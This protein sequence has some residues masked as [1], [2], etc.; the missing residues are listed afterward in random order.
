MSFRE[1]KDHA[2][3][4]VFTGAAA[5]VAGS[6]LAAIPT[7]AF[8]TAQSIG[9]GTG[10]SFVAATAA[11]ML[12]AG[13]II[14]GTVLFGAAAATLAA[15]LASAAGIEEYKFPTG[16]WAGITCGAW[17]MANM[18]GMAAQDE[19]SHADIQKLLEEETAIVEMYEEP[20]LDGQLAYCMPESPKTTI[21]PRLAA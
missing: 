11:A 12:G 6:A 21:F 2:L 17:G 9:L 3:T 18:F 16:L 19:V 14:G 5:F 1:F 20:E 7:L 15:G 13:T 10:L 8:A 4:A